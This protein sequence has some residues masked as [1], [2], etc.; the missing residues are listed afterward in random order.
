[1]GVVQLNKKAGVLSSP[2]SNERPQLRNAQVM[3]TSPASP[4]NRG[5]P[6]RRNNLILRPAPSWNLK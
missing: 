6:I 2:W 5:N 3:P 4:T 1:M